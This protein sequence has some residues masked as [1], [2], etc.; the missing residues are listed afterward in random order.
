METP[1]QAKRNCCLLVDK[2]VCFVST[3][4]T[5]KQILG[6]LA[7]Q[8][9]GLTSSI[10]VQISYLYVVFMHLHETRIGGFST[11]HITFVFGYGAYSFTVGYRFFCYQQATS[12]KRE[13]KKEFFHIFRVT[14]FSRYKKIIIETLFGVISFYTYSPLLTIS[15]IN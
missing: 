12:S 14:T 1:F 13:R 3:A 4:N 2:N 10:E 6:D 9:V 7:S 15:E 5:L 8:G 11:K